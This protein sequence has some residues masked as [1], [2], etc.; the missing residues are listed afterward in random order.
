[1]IKVLRVEL[2]R[3]RGGF[4]T[5]DKSGPIVVCQ[6]CDDCCGLRRRICCPRQPAEKRK[7]GGGRGLRRRRAAASCMKTRRVSGFRMRNASASDSFFRRHFRSIPNF[8]FSPLGADCTRLHLSSLVKGTDPPDAL[9]PSLTARTTENYH[10]LGFDR[11]AKRGTEHG[12]GCGRNPAREKGLMSKLG[13]F[14]VWAA[15]NRWDGSIAS[16]RTQLVGRKQSTNIPEERQG[17]RCA[18]ELFARRENRFRDQRR[19]RNRKARSPERLSAVW[20]PRSSWRTWSIAWKALRRNG[21]ARA[22]R[23]P[24]PEARC[25]R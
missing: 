16:A 2:E 8:S 13:I 22:T 14:W 6:G 25:H 20:K 10:F 3:R 5:F 18:K 1:M 17:D 11:F 23:R 24:R 12:Q 4:E 7:R 21:R 9:M 15:S 19:R